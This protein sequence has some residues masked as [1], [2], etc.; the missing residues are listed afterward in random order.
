MIFPERNY[1]NYNGGLSN[2]CEILI[3]TIKAL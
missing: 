3:F 1:Q 2:A